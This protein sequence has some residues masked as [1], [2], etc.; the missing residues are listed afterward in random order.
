ME[1]MPQRRAAGDLIFSW[2]DLLATRRMFARLQAHSKDGAAMSFKPR[3]ANPRRFPKGGYCSTHLLNM[4]PGCSR[5]SHSRRMNYAPPIFG[6]S[7]SCPMR[8]GRFLDKAAGT[9]YD[10]ATRF[11]TVV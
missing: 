8:Q 1:K 2:A 4:E 3:R 6:T 11:L 5:G 9:F 10:L 7:C